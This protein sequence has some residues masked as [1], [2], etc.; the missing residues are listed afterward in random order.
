MPVQVNGK[1]RAVARRCRPRSDA[2]TR[3]R[4]RR[5]PTSG[6]SQRWTVVDVKR[7]VV[8]PGRLVNFVV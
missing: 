8:V 1:V 3:S 5:E 4:R 7:V 6:S 2:G